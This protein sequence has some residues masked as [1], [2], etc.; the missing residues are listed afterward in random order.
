MEKMLEILRSVLENNEK[1]VIVSQWTSMLTIISTC[2]KQ[3]N[4]SHDTFSGDIPN[5]ERPKLVRDFNDPSNGL[6]VRSIQFNPKCNIFLNFEL[7]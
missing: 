4:I 7:I 2:L 3:L 6:K 5:Q 1:A